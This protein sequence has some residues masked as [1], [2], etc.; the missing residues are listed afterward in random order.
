[1]DS[2]EQAAGEARVRALLIDALERRGLARPS[3]LT[4]AQYEDMCTDLCRR[5]AYMSALS[6]AALEEQVASNPSGKDLDRLPIGNKIL[7][8]AGHIQPPE[9]GA[10]PLM[11]AVF[12]HALGVGAIAEGWAP[13]LLEYLASKRLWPNG[14]AVVKLRERA[15]AS[16]RRMAII[17]ERSVAGIEPSREDERWR[18]VRLAQIRKCRDIGDLARGEVA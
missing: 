4:K 14:Y 18:A 8:W 6:L 17:E 15:D 2:A 9:H 11:R 1:M 12:G 7:E 10:S 5:L 3:T 16:V 13:E